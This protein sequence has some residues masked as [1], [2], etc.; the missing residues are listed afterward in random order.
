MSTVDLRLS[1]LRD[2]LSRWL[3]PG[4]V[5]EAWNERNLYREIA[6]FGVLSG[7]N[8]TF[9]SVFALRLGAS[10]LLV[11]LLS[12][13]PALV[14]VLFQIPAARLVERESDRRRVIL[15]SGLLMRLPVFLMALVPLLPQHL[16]AG[17]VVCIATLGNVP[18]AVGTV[19]FTAML[20]DVVP[21]R[22][23]SRVV[24]V[25]NAMLATATTVTVLTAGK[26]LDILPFPFSYQII[27]T[28]AFAASVV[29]LYYLGRVVI[30]GGG[31]PPERVPGHGERLDLRRAVPLILGQ[32]DYVRFT[33]GSFVYHWGLHFPIALYS[34]YRVR[35]LQLS[36]GW[37]GALAMLESGVTI[38][39]YYSMGKLAQRYGSRTVLLIGLVLVCLYPIGMALSS[40]PWPL[41]FVALIAGIAGPAFNLGLFNKLLEV[42]PAR[43]RATYIALFNT[44][45]NTAAFVSPLLGT[46]AAT[47]LGIRQALWIGGA[48]RLLGLLAFARLL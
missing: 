24:S 27:F 15:L 28:L 46:S 29:S 33:L 32:R 42:A 10:N 35:E 22:D 11:G 6:W 36:E 1:R 25:R 19:S 23:R 7:V 39:A 34:I 43:R 31:E 12:S 37:I 26:V 18:A 20:A 3:A 14:N 4:E 30:K 13:L 41:L 2:L 44:L 21:P 5:A 16:R 8:A 9:V 38:I 17:A 40:T 47:W 45:M 48:G